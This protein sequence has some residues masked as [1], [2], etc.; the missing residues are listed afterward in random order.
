MS[1][2]TRKSAVAIVGSGLSPKADITTLPRMPLCSQDRL[3]E[4]AEALS[5]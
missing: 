4:M 5:V 2:Q 3:E 1:K